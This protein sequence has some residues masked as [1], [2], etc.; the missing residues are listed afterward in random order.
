MDRK[1]RLMPELPEVETIKCGLEPSLTHAKI[2]A[3]KQHRADLRYPFPENFVSHLIGSQIVGLGRRAKYLLIHL[4][5]D[6]TI[7]SHLGMSGSWILEDQS[8]GT[9]HHDKQRLIKHNHFAMDIET[10]KGRIFH[11]VYNDPRRFGFML[12]TKTK[13]LAFHKLLANLGPEPTGNSLS[14][15][16][17][18]HS[19]RNKKTSLKSALLDQRL[20]AGLGN[21]YVCEALWRSRLSPLRRS[22][23]LGEKTSLACKQSELLAE[24]I[25]NVIADA[26]KAGGSTL[27]D[28]VHTDGSLGY[29]Q[30][31]F[32]VYQCEG[33]P[34]PQCGKPI[35]RTVQSGRSS[36]Y[37]EHCQK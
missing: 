14:G 9:Y 23:T 10:P 26:I 35:I 19:L 15:D 4:D 32:S 34:C 8:I 5:N 29:F 22:S 36:F 28:Y 16:Y 37:C 27:R 12:I 1:I 31:R 11:L 21:I 6:E 3:A 33:K 25:R 13:D 30:H 18:N 2:I 7:I 17:L 24:N 20:I